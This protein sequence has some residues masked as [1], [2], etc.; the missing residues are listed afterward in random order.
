MRVPVQMKPTSSPAFSAYQIETTDGY[1]LDP[2]VTS[3]PKVIPLAGTTSAI[4]AAIKTPRAINLILTR[5][6]YSQN[7]LFKLKKRS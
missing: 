7:S 6:E 1:A 3:R 2:F 5:T 4:E